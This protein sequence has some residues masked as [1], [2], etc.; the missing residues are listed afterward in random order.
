V[1]DYQILPKVFLS[2]SAAFI[3]MGFVKKQQQQQKKTE[4][5]F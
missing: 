1:R 5:N 3:M 4:T 2:L